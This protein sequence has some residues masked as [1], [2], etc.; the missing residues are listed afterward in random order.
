MNVEIFAKWL[1]RQGHRVIQSES[2]YWYDAGPRVFQAF[3]YAWLIEPSAG[4]LRRLMLR[5]GITALRYSTPLG[6][7]EGRVSYH[8][9]LHAPYTLEG[10]RAQARNGV[11]RGLSWFQVERISFER[12]AADGWALQADTLERQGRARSMDQATWRRIC[13]AG[14][15]LPGFEAWGATTQQG[16]LAAALFTARIDGTCYVPYALS[17]SNYL[18]EHVNNAIFYAVSS[19]LLTRE[20]VSK[21]FFTVQSLDAPESV[22][23]FKFR[24]SLIPKPVCQR[25]VFHP[26][27]APLARDETY[28]LVCRL[29]ERDP[30]SPL[31]AKAEGMLRFHLQGKAPQTAQVWPACLEEYRAQYQAE[32][33]DAKSKPAR[34]APAGV[35]ATPGAVAAE[36]VPAE[37]SS[38]NVASARGTETD[39]AI[40]DESPAK[41][42]A[43]VRPV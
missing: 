2:S 5:H 31:L 16:E 9:V 24:M 29:L 30:G 15:G 13:L 25:V 36:G 21:I 28:R 8:V 43:R 12:L 19:D 39:G 38:T 11:K 10:L 22:D 4:E 6:A 7:A 32:D 17:H 33:L 37:V 34:H 20:L 14:E 23:D 27:L 3:P 42:R 18:R 40:I 35:T 41:V 26:W 1:R